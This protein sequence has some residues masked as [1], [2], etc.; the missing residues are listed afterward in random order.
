RFSER[1]IL[2]WLAEQ[3]A[4]HEVFAVLAANG[5]NDGTRIDAFMDVE[6]YRLNVERIALYPSRPMKGR[7]EV[8]VVRIG[9]LADVPVGF[10]GY[11]PDRRIVDSLLLA[12]RVVFDL[13][14]GIGRLFF[15]SPP[16]AVRDVGVVLAR[17]A[18]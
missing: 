8:R 2:V 4:L 1:R 17:A 10:G 13:S 18:F 16:S 11:E 5:L 6:R 14:L 9:L 15:H 7:I 3:R 12:M